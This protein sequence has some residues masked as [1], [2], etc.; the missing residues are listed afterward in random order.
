MENQESPIEQLIQKVEDYGK[1]TFEL[2]KCTA[3]SESAGFISNIASKLIFTVVMI[4]FLSLVNIGAS[5]WI[6]TLL[7][8]PYFGFF[9]VA[10]FYLV[11]GLVIYLLRNELLKTPIS[12]WIIKS[13][14][15]EEL[16]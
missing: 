11:A 3:V 7:N 10:L 8:E 9:I 15:K 12:N 6:G 13:F 14:M 5:L 16:Q 4:L 1:T 2:Y